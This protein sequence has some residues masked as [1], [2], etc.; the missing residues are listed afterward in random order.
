MIN[1]KRFTKQDASRLK[2][3]STKDLF[4]KVVEYLESSVLLLFNFRL[5]D[6]TYDAAVTDQA[7]KHG[8]NGIPSDVILVYKNPS[9]AT[10]TFKYENFT[11]DSIIVTTSAPCRIRFLAGKYKGS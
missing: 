7:I 3:E 5:Y 10:V 2:D 1:I 6:V 9:T 8:Q 11:N 4:F